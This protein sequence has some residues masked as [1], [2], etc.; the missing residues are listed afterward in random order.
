M[1]PEV[2]RRACIRFL[3]VGGLAVSFPE[4]MIGK[5]VN[6][7]VRARKTFTAQIIG[8]SPIIG[9]EQEKENQENPKAETIL[10]PLRDGELVLNFPEGNVEIGSYNLKL[11]KGA[12]LKPEP[13]ILSI[14]NSAN[15]LL[16]L[17]FQNAVNNLIVKNSFRYFSEKRSYSDIWVNVYTGVVNPENINT[18]GANWE[19][20]NFQ[21][22]WIN[23]LPAR[24]ILRRIIIP[25][26]YMS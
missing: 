1:S 15:F 2:S 6:N 8:G 14:S 24:P 12:L 7:F 20:G 26:D 19:N 10:F 16:S 25:P 3:T 13:V 4:L 22:F 23:D 5:L 21:K 17:S 9:Q 18:F 11:K